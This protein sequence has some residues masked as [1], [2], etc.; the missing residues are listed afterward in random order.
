MNVDNMFA[1]RAPTPAQKC[2]M[3]SLLS[4]ARLIARE[5]QSATPA[6]PNHLVGANLLTRNLTPRP[7]VALMKK[8][9]T[10]SNRR[11]LLERSSRYSRRT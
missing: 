6:G 9:P 5:I 11:I 2:R 10:T 8:F 4:Y 7:P 3:N 1:H